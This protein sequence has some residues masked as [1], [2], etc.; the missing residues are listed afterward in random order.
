MLK[1]VGNVEV[2]TSK[3]EENLDIGLNLIDINVNIKLQFLMV[4]PEFV[5]CDYAKSPHNL[6]KSIEY[7]EFS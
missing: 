6:K 2:R 3:N 5:R 1:L 7:I 4:L